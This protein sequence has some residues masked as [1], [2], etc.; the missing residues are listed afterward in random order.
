MPPFTMPLAHS[1]GTAGLGAASSKVYA[2]SPPDSSLTRRAL[3]AVCHRGPV[4]VL[5][6][7]L[8][9]VGVLLG[10]ASKSIA[11]WCFHR[12]CHSP[13]GFLPLD[14]VGWL[15][16][17]PGCAVGVAINFKGDRRVR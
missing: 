15:Y 2:L 17:E 3:A 9:F 7:R 5:L 12:Y 13:H 14:G 16:V 6:W 11:G 10:G 8:C 4:N 1:F